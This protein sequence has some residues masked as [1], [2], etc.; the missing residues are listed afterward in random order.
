MKLNIENYPY[1]SMDQDIVILIK[2]GKYYFPIYRVK[3]SAKDKK[4]ILQKIFN[5][6]DVKTNNIIKD[7]INKISKK[8]EKESYKSTF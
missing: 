5:I 8:H 6:N 4:I 7:M 3:K 2:D 1:I